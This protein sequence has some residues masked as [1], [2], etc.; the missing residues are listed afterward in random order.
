MLTF[1]LNENVFC[2]R[3]FGHV[4]DSD[5]SISK[6]T[7]VATKNLHVLCILA[8]ELYHLIDEVNAETVDAEKKKR[9]QQQQEEMAAAFS[10]AADFLEGKA[11]KDRWLLFSSSAFL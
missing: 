11:A 3:I 10:N 9:K 2:R 1:K 8:S 7:A 6:V 4:E 5:R